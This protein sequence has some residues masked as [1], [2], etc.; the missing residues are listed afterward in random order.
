MTLSKRGGAALLI[1]VAWGLSMA[2]LGVRRGGGSDS[3]FLRSQASLRLAE[4]EAW[5]RV[6]AGTVQIGTAGIT[7][8]T[9]NSRYRIRESVTLHLPTATGVQ[10]TIRI[11]DYYL[12]P[13]LAVDSILSHSTTPGSRSDTRVTAREGGWDTEWQLDSG[14]VVRGRLVDS[15]EPTSTT[16]PVPLTVMP[17]RLA[18]VGAVAAGQSRNLLVA[19]G[20]P[21]SAS[22]T[23]VTPRSDTVLVFADSSEM[24]PVTGRWV[25]AHLD[26]LSTRE[27]VVPGIAGPLRLRVDA[28]GTIAALETQFGV[29][30]EREEFQIA[31]FNYRN[32]LLPD[33]SRLRAALPVVRQLSGSGLDRDSTATPVRYAVTR[34]DGRNLA[35]PL[36]VLVEGARQRIEPG[37]NTIVVQPTSPGRLVD[38]SEDPLVQEYDPA[39]AALSDSIVGRFPLGSVIAR[40]R[41]RVAVDT[42]AGAAMDA[43]G[44]LRRGRARPEGIARL[45]VA[46]LRRHRLQA[47]LA[48]GVLPVGD[49][50]YTHAWVEVRD[51]GTRW[52]LAVDPAGGGPASTRLVR[53]AGTGSSHPTQLMPRI[54]DVRF[55]PLAPPQPP[56]E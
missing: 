22:W 50:L 21:P 52:W 42:A 55:R 54:A 17:F 25:A 40:V 18:L 36:F 30:W 29:R 6:M 48:V 24:D 15:S 3:A 12:S 28:R 44:A 45:A 11:T 34:R 1:V 4:S 31:R 56:E 53:V 41:A 51:P 7:L 43:A 47:Q 35:G 20:W 37:S 16:P 33:G 23:G 10:P 13:S 5:F 32:D 38:E 49:T 19:D 9:L 39:V 46:I 14:G 8:D 26:T 27:L 2:W